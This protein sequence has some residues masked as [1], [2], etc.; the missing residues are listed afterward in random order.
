ML[1]LL[2]LRPHVGVGRAMRAQLAGAVAAVLPALAAQVAQEVDSANGWHV[3]GFRCAHCL[4]SSAHRRCATPGSSAHQ[5][6]PSCATARLLFVASRNSCE[7]R[8]VMSWCAAA[9]TAVD[10]CSASTI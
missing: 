4:H 2:L 7:S 9:S 3:K 8:A 10:G 1:V 6:V 5:A